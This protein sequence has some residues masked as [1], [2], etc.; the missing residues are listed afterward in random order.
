MVESLATFHSN[1]TNPASY[2]WCSPWLCP[3]TSFIYHL[4]TSFWPHLS[5]IYHL[6]SLPC[7]WHHA[8]P[9]HHPNYSLSSLPHWQ[10][11]RLDKTW[12]QIS[13]IPASTAFAIHILVTFCTD[14]CNSY[15]F[16]KVFFISQ[17]T[18]SNWFRSL[19]LASLP[20]PPPSLACC[21]ST[22]PAKL[23]SFSGPPVALLASSQ[24]FHRLQDFTSY[25]WGRP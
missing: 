21:N 19:P 9:V 1:V 14:Y 17:S 6:F 4:T 7:R 2:F 5:W 22:M 20:K 16:L 23:P 12:H 15:F 8:L 18:N 11:I 13:H 24:I 3:G 10:H 25:L